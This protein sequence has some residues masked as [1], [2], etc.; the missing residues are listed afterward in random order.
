MNSKGHIS[1]SI[2]GASL[3]PIIS[4][5]SYNYLD[6]IGLYRI[7]ENIYNYFINYYYQVIHGEHIINIFI[8]LL[9][10]VIGSGLPDLDFNFKYFYS[11]RS[12]IYRY[13]RQIT[14]S[15]ILNLS[16]FI[17]SLYYYNPI[18]FFIWYG[19]LIHLIGDMLTGSIPILLWGKYYHYFS[20]IGIDR[21]YPS[22]IDGRKI[23]S[24]IAKF[25][26]NPIVITIII[27]ISITIFINEYKF[28]IS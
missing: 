8:M 15:L 12:K 22:S 20:R 21:F 2:L 23:N 5:K 17:Y 25:F 26:D 24:K 9:L 19:V 27:V 11:D 7:S 4:Y 18:I 28:F 1:Q 6:E 10:I 16:I 13:H 14:H 3:F